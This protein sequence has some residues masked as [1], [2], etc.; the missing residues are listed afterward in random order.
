MG[1]A[2]PELS[3]GSD[4]AATSERTDWKDSQ[5]RGFTKRY[6]GAEFGG[7]DL[8]L[9]ALERAGASASQLVTTA[10]HDGNHVRDTD[11]GD[12]ARSPIIVSRSL[13][14]E[15]PNETFFEQS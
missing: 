5:S 9:L 14:L 8:L 15:R 3:A 10:A 11:D 12:S 13:M 1:G 4:T 2:L 7:D 6:R